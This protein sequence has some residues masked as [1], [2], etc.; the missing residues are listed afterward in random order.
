MIVVV[1]RD[2]DCVDN[3]YVFDFTWHLRVAL[4]AHEGAGGATVLEDWVEENSQT[5]GKLE[6]VACMA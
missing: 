4:W 6:I 2:H 1:V 3:G 5:A